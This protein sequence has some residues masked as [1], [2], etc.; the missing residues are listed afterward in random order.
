MDRGQS[1]QIGTPY[2]IYERPSTRFVADFMGQINCYE[3]V[4]TK[5]IKNTVTITCEPF[6]NVTAVIPTG[7]DY[8]IKDKV[9]FL[10]RKEGITILFNENT[11]K[12]EINSVMVTVQVASYIGPDIEYIC[13]FGENINDQITLRAPTKLKPS[14]LPKRG[15]KIRLAW[16]TSDIFIVEKITSKNA[17]E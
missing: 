9:F 11:Q 13:I 7:K 1:I 8:R 5:K 10:I 2:D 15:D 16:E 14:Q 12:K 6:L 17:N 3:G 4:I